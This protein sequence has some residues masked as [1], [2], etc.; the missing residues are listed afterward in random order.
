MVQPKAMVLILEVAPPRGRLVGS[1][2][3]GVHR[4]RTRGNIDIEDW[5]FLRLFRGSIMKLLGMNTGNV[6]IDQRGR[7]SL[8]DTNT[9]PLPED[10]VSLPVVEIGFSPI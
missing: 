6:V 4:R 5:R 8:A 2:I 9:L 1:R 7:G 10:V 3:L